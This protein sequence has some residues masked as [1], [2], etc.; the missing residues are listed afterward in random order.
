MTFGDY[1]RRVR[2]PSTPRAELQEIAELALGKWDCWLGEAEQMLAKL[3]RGS[4]MQERLLDVL[5]Q[6]RAMLGLS[7]DIESVP[8]ADRPALN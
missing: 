5:D 1:L 6:Y 3:Q 4:A 2:D 7:G 8:P